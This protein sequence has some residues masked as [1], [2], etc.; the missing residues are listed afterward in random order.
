MS[1]DEVMISLVF[2]GTAA[3][4]YIRWLSL[5]LT[6]HRVPGAQRAPLTLLPLLCAGISML[7]LRALADAAVR[8]STPYQAMYMVIGAGWVWSAAALAQ[9]LGIGLRAD[10]LERRNAAALWVYRGAFAGLWLA[11][12]GGNFG[13]GPGWWVVLACAVMTSA[14]LLAAWYAV[15]VVTNLAERITVDRDIAGG[16]RFAG[17]L[18][19]AGLAL[20]RGAA[21]DWRGAA[22][23]GEDILAVGAPA[24]LALVAAECALSLGLRRVSSG[25]ARVFAQGV[26]PA[27]IYVMGSAM[28]VISRGPWQ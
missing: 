13:D 18:V 28:W 1:E 27:A 6:A 17:L 4:F 10:V 26:A 9:L 2:G 16:I 22:N 11:Y 20:G 23:A 8:A 14:L 12:L 25:A 5:A 19:A 21:G 3:G 15:E 7:A 24:L